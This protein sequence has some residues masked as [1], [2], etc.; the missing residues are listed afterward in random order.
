MKGED[1]FD[2]L[3]RRGVTRLY[4]ANSV[5]TSISLLKLAGLA[6]RQVVEKAGLPQTVQY[7]DDLDKACGIWN[8]VFLD[9]VDIHARISDRNKYGPVLFVF[10]IEL[11]L[12]LP[13]SSDVLITRS[14]P[15]K[16][17]PSTPIAQRYFLNP[18]ELDDD[19]EVGNFDHMLII[20]NGEGKVKFG[21]DFQTVIVDEPVLNN[22][23][24][25]EFRAAVSGLA[26]AAVNSGIP[27]EILR[28]PC[29]P[30]CRCFSSYAARPDRIRWFYSL[31]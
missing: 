17:S 9:M 11:L 23:E 8:D 19:L 6:S 28:R 12:N 2:I 10:R 24:G 18:D 26:N 21:E 20:R 29:V 1:V 22:G 16:W 4:H 5:R 25:P 27:L 14:N 13:P 15:S 7:T 30:S 3:S 31:A